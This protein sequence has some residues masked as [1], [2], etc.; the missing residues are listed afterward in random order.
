MRENVKLTDVNKLIKLIFNIF[1]FIITFNIIGIQKIIPDRIENSSFFGYKS[2]SQES[3][4][5]NVRKAEKYCFYL[6]TS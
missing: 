6:T 1:L 5:K 4:E 3:L 2:K